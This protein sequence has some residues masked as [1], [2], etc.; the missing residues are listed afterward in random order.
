MDQDEID[1]M[2]LSLADELD[3]EGATI[4]MVARAMRHL[5]AREEVVMQKV[6]EMR[7]DRPL[8]SWPEPEDGGPRGLPWLTNP[9]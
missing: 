7:Q 3:D 4:G 2:A 6:A 1:E 9:F 8:P 5:G